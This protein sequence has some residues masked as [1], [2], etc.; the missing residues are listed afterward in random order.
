MLFSETVMVG[1][2]PAFYAVQAKLDGIHNHLWISLNPLDQP[3]D[4]GRDDLLRWSSVG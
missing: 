2:Q 3:S 1:T 4:T